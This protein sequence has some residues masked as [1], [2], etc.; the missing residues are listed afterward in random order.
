MA[1]GFRSHER[2]PGRHRSTAD[3]VVGASV[4]VEVSHPARSSRSVARCA[5]I[6]NRRFRWTTN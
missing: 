2:H 1:E 6:T 4:D 3:S 5:N